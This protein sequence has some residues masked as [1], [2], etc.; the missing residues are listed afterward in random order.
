MESRATAS[1]SESR[2]AT[3]AMDWAIS[4]NSWLRQAMWATPKKKMMGNS[5][6]APSPIMTAA[7][8]WPGAKVALSSAR[9]AHD[10]A[11]QPITHAA[12]NNAAMKYGV[13]AGRRCRGAR[14]VQMY[15]ES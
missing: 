5:E 1:G 7:D 14:I 12:E 9:K 15:G 3:P 10:R 8:E 11:R 6:A 13:R 4:R 2:M